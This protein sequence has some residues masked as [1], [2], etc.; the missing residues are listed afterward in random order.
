MGFGAGSGVCTGVG[1]DS[2][3]GAG[4]DTGDD[5]SGIGD[6]SDGCCCVDGGV[7]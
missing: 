5:S 6:D 2:G 1:V 3:I 4:V 7:V